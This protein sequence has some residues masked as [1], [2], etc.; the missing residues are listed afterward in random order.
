MAEINAKINYGNLKKL[1]EEMT[2]NYTVKVGL[3]AEKNGSEEVSPNLDMAG[4]GAVH[5][6]GATI[7]VTDKM[8]A[9]FRYA[10]GINLKKSTKEIKIPARSWLEMPI[11]RNNGADLRKLIKEKADL[12]KNDIELVQEFISEYGESGILKDLA[13][14]VGVSA[15]EQI[16]K[17]FESEGF[18]EWQSDS[19]LTIKNKNSSM[20]LIDK[21][22]FRKTI[23]YDIEEK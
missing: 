5:E 2:K 20:P 9:Y 15:K 16:D 11:T 6:F 8:R 10:Y 13:L 3:L 17:A 7:K 23:T 12:T 21:G 19:P 1:V 18:G 22:R 14:A 4:L